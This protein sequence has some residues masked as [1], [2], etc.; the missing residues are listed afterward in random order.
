MACTTESKR[1]MSD[2]DLRFTRQRQ[3]QI[4]LPHR[5]NIDRTLIQLR[6]L[7]LVSPTQ[8]G[9]GERVS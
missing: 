1:L 5:A 7:D 8:P 9:D 6:N 2:S 4:R 3:A